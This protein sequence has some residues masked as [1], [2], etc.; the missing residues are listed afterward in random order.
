MSSPLE[1]VP[2]AL[3]DALLEHF[4]P[5]E[6]IEIAQ[7]YLDAPEEDQAGMLAFVTEDG[8]RRVHEI[9]LKHESG[10]PTSADLHRWL[11]RE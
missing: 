8:P 7:A 5:S 1:S 2:A 9:R 11:E 4:D 3:L 6:A 10:T